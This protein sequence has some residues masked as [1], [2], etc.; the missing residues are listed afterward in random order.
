MRKRSTIRKII[1]LSP[2]VDVFMIVIFWYIM[3][4]SQNLKNQE[5]EFQE[6][7][8]NLEKTLSELGAESEKNAASLELLKHQKESLEMENERMAAVMEYEGRYIL[9]WFSGGLTD[10]REIK[11]IFDGTTEE[12]SFSSE[13]REKG[14]FSARLKTILEKYFG[15]GKRCNVIFLY[16]GSNSYSR[17]IAAIEATILK[18]QKQQY[19]VYTKV[20]LSR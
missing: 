10:Q 16:D 19:F 15:A 1:N 8:N 20:N 6:T 7:I 11:V 17:D 13:D 12:L 4:S 18:L 14:E 2:L 9:L 3:F 5:Q